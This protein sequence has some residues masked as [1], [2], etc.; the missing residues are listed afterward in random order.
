MPD[1]NPPDQ[2]DPPSNGPTARRLYEPISHGHRRPANGRTR[3]RRTK[4]D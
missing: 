1:L 4:A 3:H 2:E